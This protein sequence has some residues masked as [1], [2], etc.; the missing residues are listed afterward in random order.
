M[1][2]G[3][4][5]LGLF[6]SAN[7]YDV[8]DD[9]DAEE[10]VASVGAAIAAAAMAAD[11]SPSRHGRP[12]VLRGLPDTPDDTKTAD[13]DATVPGLL[14]ITFNSRWLLVA[15]LVW[16][17]P[18]LWACPT[19]STAVKPNAKQTNVGGDFPH[20]FDISSEGTRVLVFTDKEQ[21]TPNVGADSQDG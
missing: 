2:A 5:A 1:A 14:K 4:H 15:K 11:G 8:K 18:T 19:P 6:M 9:D 21:D 7:A 10:E 17:S 3:T 13:V 16:S 12:L 20:L